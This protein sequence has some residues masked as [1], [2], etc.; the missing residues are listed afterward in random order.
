MMGDQWEFQDMIQSSGYEPGIV[1]LDSFTCPAEEEVA[2]A[3]QISIEEPVL[4]IR[5]VFTADNKPAIYSINILPQTLQNRPHDPEKIKGPIFP[6]LQEAY[7]QLPAYSVTDLIPVIAT[8][9]LTSL[10]KVEP[11][12]PLLLFKDIFYNAENQPILYGHNH[13][14]DLLHFKAI[15]QPNSNRV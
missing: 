12:S 15:R 14:T 2:L 11:Q 7:G 5:K 13:F 10:L 3:L 4:K 8:P 1:F 6:Y 9:D